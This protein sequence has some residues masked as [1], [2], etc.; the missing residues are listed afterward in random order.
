MRTWIDLADIEMPQR[1]TDLARDTRGYPIPYTVKYDNNGLP[2]F[3]VIDVDKWHRAIKA[4]CCGI[5]GITLGGRI[6]FVGGPVSIANR[7][8]NDLPMH[9]DCAEYAMRVCPFIAAP[10]FMYARM[11]P[12]GTQVN[13]H[14][15]DERPDQFGLGISRGFEVVQL[16][17]GVLALHAH[18]FESVEWWKHGQVLVAA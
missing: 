15:C 18:T 3:R 14:V 10:K 6:A 5:C 2:D 11:L 9:R 8:F 13:E 7:L 16:A 17:G 1:V 12:E 4:R